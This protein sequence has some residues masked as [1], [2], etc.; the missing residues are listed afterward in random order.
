MASVR[1]YHN[2]SCSKSRETLALLREQGVEPEV[3]QYLKT[4]PTA[5][6]I[7]GLA[8]QLGGSPQQLLRT[9]EAEYAASG[10]DANSGVR[11]IAEAIAAAPRLLERPIVVVGDRAAI[12][13]P[14]ENVL[15]L[16]KGR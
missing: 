5:A 11:A 12:G 16:L 2:P 14:P 6:E 13:R 9:K 8:K 1:I 4:P 10:L 15:A 7:E 3:L